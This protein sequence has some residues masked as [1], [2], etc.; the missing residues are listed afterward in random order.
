[1]YDMTNYKCNIET[2]ETKND[3]YNIEI[4]LFLY[5]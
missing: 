2:D 5:Q 1:M 3:Y 4:Y